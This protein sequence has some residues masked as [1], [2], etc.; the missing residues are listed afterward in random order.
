MNQMCRKCDRAN[1]CPR[2]G[3]LEPIPCPIGQ[4][5]DMPQ[6]AFCIDCPDERRCNETEL[7][8]PQ[9]CPRGLHFILILC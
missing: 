2:K 3:M 9:S 1:K 4:Y 7:Q 8:N 6:R 5:Q